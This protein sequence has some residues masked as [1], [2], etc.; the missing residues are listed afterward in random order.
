MFLMQHQEHGH[1]NILEW[2]REKNLGISKVCGISTFVGRSLINSAIQS[3][4]TCVLQW[5]DEKELITRAILQDHKIQLSI[6]LAKKA[7]NT[8]MIEWFIN[9][10]HELDLQLNI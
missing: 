10:A 7:G 1:I 2:A 6:V 5:I 8:E 9:K 3:S 4:Q